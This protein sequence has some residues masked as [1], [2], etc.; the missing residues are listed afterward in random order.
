MARKKAA[1]HHGGAWK[2][3]YADFVTAMM[4]LF[5]VLWISSQN[6]K[7]LIATA[8]YFQNPFRSPMD[9]SSGVMPFNTNKTTASSGKE[10]GDEKEMSRS[11][12]IQMTFLNSVAAD[13]YR[14]LNLDQD[15]ANKPIDVQVTSDGL[16]IT[17]YDRAKRPLFVGDTAEFTPW[18]KFVMQNLAWNI[19]RHQFR[20]TIDGHTRQRPPSATVP[21]EPPAYTDWELSSD[22]ANAA[23]RSL[24]HYAIDPNLI[25][26]VTGYADTKPMAGEP[27]TSDSNQRVTLSLTL[28]AKA[29]LK[30]KVM[31]QEKV[32]IAEEPA[33]ALKA[34]T[35]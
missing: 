4:A 21:A 29:R 25:E 23:R 28:S 2:V 15:L 24:V 1:A 9:A 17:L 12:H 7:I 27:P 33:D 5:M 34:K 10:A 18:G 22:R 14:L 6:Q 26:R 8:Q 31:V 19:D 13:F 16:R 32:P 30:D 3:A 35:P 20:V 11:K